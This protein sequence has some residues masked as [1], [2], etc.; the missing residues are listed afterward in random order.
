[1]RGY[2]FELEDGVLSDYNRPGLTVVAPS[3]PPQVAGSTILL[4][5]LLSSYRGKLNAIAGYSR[6]AKSDPAFQAPCPFRQ[7]LLPRTFPALY[8]RLKHRFPRLAYLSIRNSIRRILEDLGTQVVLAT[9]PFEVNLVATFFAARELGLP[10]YVHMHDLW[11]EQ[12]PEGTAAAAF[13]KEWEPVIFKDSTRILC[14]TEAMQ[15]HYQVKYGIKTYLLPHCIPEN[16]KSKVPVGIRPATMTTPTVLFVGAVQKDMNLDSLKT[17]ASA[18]ELLPTDYELLFCTSSDRVTLNRLGIQSSRLRVKY[19]SRA[20]VQCLQSQAHVLV[21]PL[22]HKD[23]A[24]DEIRTVFSTKLLEYLV[25]G[26]PIVVYAPEGSYHVES[27]RKHGW[28][29]VVTEDSPAALAAAIR[30]VA[31]NEDLAAELVRRA[32]EEARTRSA[33]YHAERLQQWVLA[34]SRN[35]CSR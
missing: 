25:S 7:L 33:S 8:D 15:R 16:G 13:A 30:E 31:S 6:Y 26:R 28:G 12:I 10:L 32:L 35:L 22:S 4:A 5:N 14:M 9:F 34:D 2:S 27:A 19:V 20:E 21:A 29:Y 24:M 1:M 3:F 23:C 11:M 17:L 18:S